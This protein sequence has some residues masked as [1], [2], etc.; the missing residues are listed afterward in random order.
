MLTRDAD[1]PELTLGSSASGEFEEDEL[2][3]QTPQISMHGAIETPHRAEP[4]GSSYRV[5]DARVD[6]VSTRT[7]SSLPPAPQDHPATESPREGAAHDGEAR[8]VPPALAMNEAMPSVIVDMGDHVN[9]LVLD[10]TRCGPEDEG[11]FVEALVR[12]GEIALPTLAQ[13]FPGP[14]WFDRNR[15]HRRLPH[16]RDVS[17]I[18][19]ALVA[20]RERAVPYVESLLGAG[21]PDRRFYA[22]L[23]AGD[24]VYPTL[25]AALSARVFDDDDGARAAALEV[26]PRFQMFSS[27]WNVSISIVRRAA[28]LRG[29]DPKRRYR[30]T[31]ALGALRDTNSLHVLLDLIE[32]EDPELAAIAHQSLVEVTCEDM[33]TSMRRWA[34]WLQKNEHRHRIEWLIDALVHADEAIRTAAG[35]E[36][37]V[38]T[39]QYYGYH[40][41][42]SR[43]DREVVQQKYRRWW[44][45]E[46]AKIW[47]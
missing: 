12:A 31:R 22:I 37:K 27:E 38:L 23:V 18:S 47:A 24:L 29:R 20:F 42:A 14:L 11:A 17:A 34:P 6:V 26:L 7:R 21:Q 25:L 33:G 16:G 19:R 44:D 32:D 36:L 1:E 41:G 45:E 30:A 4:E 8:R 13:A 43:K 15:P 2:E 9:S 3:E 28:K 40:P 35:E 10:L 39:Q 5:R 46:G